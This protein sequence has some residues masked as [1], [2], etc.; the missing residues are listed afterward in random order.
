MNIRFFQ[1]SGVNADSAVSLG[2][3][4]SVIGF[5]GQILLI[6]TI[7]AFGFGSLDLDI[8]AQLSDDTL[9][10]LLVIVAVALVAA[11][12]VILVVPKFRGAVRAAST[13]SGRS[14]APCSCRPPAS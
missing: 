8:T 6:V 14:S 11:V 12:V 3:L 9:R 2:V 4:D 1:R 13:G 10:N 7:L 5:V